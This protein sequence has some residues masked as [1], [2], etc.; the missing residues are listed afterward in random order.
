MR[1]FW[2]CTVFGLGELCGY[3]SALCLWSQDHT[4]NTMT[5]P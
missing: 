2:K 1:D 5:H 4:G 3:H